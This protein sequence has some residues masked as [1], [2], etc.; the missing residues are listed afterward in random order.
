MNT[1]YIAILAA[2]VTAALAA[3]GAAFSQG[4]STPTLKGVVGPGYTISLKKGAKKVKTLK[5]GKYR[6]SV[7]DSTKADNFHLIGPGVNKKTGVK[8]VASATWTLRLKA[9]K[10][11]YRSDATKKLRRAFAVR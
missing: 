8:A 10:Y 1:K 11:T 5:A 4:T 3:P 6:I 7:K 2:C 9:G